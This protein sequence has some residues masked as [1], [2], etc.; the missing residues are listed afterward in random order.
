M[1]HC[2][3]FRSMIQTTQA[4]SSRNHTGLTTGGRDDRV[5]MR[6]GLEMQDNIIVFPESSPGERAH[7]VTPALPLPLTPLLGR[8]QEVQAICALLSRPDVRLLTLTGTA[9]VGKTRLALEVARKLVQD[10]ADGVHLV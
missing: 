9:G 1:A 5:D 2:R 3:L 4:L 6:E 10:F 7:R 8:E